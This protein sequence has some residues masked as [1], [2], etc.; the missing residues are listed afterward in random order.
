MSSI[1]KKNA[2]LCASVA[3]D[4][5][6]KQQHTQQKKKRDKVQK[7]EF[8]VILLIPHSF[9]KKTIK[10]KFYETLDN[11][12]IKTLNWDIFKSP[13]GTKYMRFS[14]P[15]PSNLQALDII[16][17]YG[18]VKLYD[19]NLNKLHPMPSTASSKVMK[20][21]GTTGAD[22]RSIVADV[23]RNDRIDARRKK[24]RL[25]GKE[26]EHAKPKPN[27]PQMEKTGSAWAYIVIDESHSDFYDTEMEQPTGKGREFQ[28]LLDDLEEIAVIRRETYKNP[29][30]GIKYTRYC[31]CNLREEQAYCSLESFASLISNDNALRVLDKNGHRIKDANNNKLIFVDPQLV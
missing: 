9:Y 12:G 16:L 6:V 30:D 14:F 7:E 26:K 21:Q 20:K 28:E 8:W 13:K 24:S 5:A 31:V 18:G 19:H 29:K 11:A 1:A 10:K 17:Q 22:I 23:K 15:P 2:P 25:R 3:Y 4:E 27:I